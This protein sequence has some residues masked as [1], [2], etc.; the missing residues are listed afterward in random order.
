MAS[1]AGGALFVKLPDI[2]G[3]KKMLSISLAFLFIAT[4]S[5]AL[6]QNKVQFFLVRCVVGLSMGITFP[7]CVAFS[8]EI[9]KS[10]HREVGPMSIVLFSSLGSFLTAVL[11]FLLLNSIGWRWFILVMVSPVAL[12]F[13]VLMCFFPESPRYLAVS[14]KK[15]EALRALHQMAKMN[16]TTLPEQINITVPVHSDPDLGSISDILKSDFRKETILL[17][18]IY[19]GNLLIIFGTQVFFPLALYSGFCGGQGDPPVHKCVKIQ[20]DSLLQLSIITFAAALSGALGYAAAMTLGRNISFKVFS[21]CSFVV[22]FFLFKCFSKLATVGLF[23]LI[24]L[25]QISH[26]TVS[27]IVV[28][29]LYPTTFRNTALGFINSWGK[30]GGVVGAGAV[31]ALYYY[32]PIFIVVMF[33]GSAFLVLVSSWVWSKETKKVIMTDVREE[34]T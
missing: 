19:F 13:I 15:T 22:T 24:K 20:Q 27:L 1:L 12:C 9:T 32:R 14:G 5:S 10:S 23:F 29:E 25:L 2:Y 4:A 21:T 30:L 16:N 11:A 28:P 18:V 26:Y 3:R 7:T 8:T 17:S 34:C 33:S 31:Y 6:A